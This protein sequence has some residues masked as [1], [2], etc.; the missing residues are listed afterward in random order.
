MGTSPRAIGQLDAVHPHRVDLGV[1]L[2]DLAPTGGC[3]D[4]SKDSP[5]L[6]T[7]FHIVILCSEGGADQLV[8]LDIHRHQPGSLV[9]IRPGQVHER[10]PQVVGT[11][12]CFT[13]TFLRTPGSEHRGPTSW[14]LGG[15]DLLDVQ[16]HLGVLSHEYDRHVFGATGARL[17]GGEALLRHLLEAFLLRVAQAPPEICGMQ[18]H[19]HPVARQFLDLVERS[20]GSIHTVEEYALAL[21]YSPKTLCRASV[22]ATG[23]TPKQVI[24]QR[25]VREARRLLAYTDLPCAAVGRRL[26]FEDA[27]NFCRFFARGTGTSPTEFRDTFAH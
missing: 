8:D 13:D 10:P 1:C 18:V 23:L 21:G 14:Q 19:P 20:Y 15:E 27:A 12:I 7:D 6:R 3:M 2:A 4:R 22:E 9:W 17:T 11:A 16:A 5:L 25:L 24:D 26:G